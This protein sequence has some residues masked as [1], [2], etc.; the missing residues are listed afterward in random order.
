MLFKFGGYN[1]VVKILQLK[2][3]KSYFAAQILQLRFHHSNFT[4]QCIFIPRP[5]LACYTV[6]TFS[7]FLYI[8]DNSIVELVFMLQ[9][10]MMKHSLKELHFLH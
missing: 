6:D 7:F 1:F 10:K 3:S 2:L 5:C 8:M 9:E 4:A